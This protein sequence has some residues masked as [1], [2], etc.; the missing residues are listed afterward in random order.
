M[1]RLPVDQVRCIHLEGSGCY[2]HNGAD[3][4]GADAALLAIALP[5]RP[6][7]VQWMREE[8]HAWEPYGAAMVSSARARLDAQGNVTEWQYEVW[9]NSHNERPGPAGNLAPAWHVQKPFAKPAPKPAPQ[10]AGGGDRN[11]IP[12][13]KFGNIRVL[14]HFIPEMPLR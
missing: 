7:R 2:G 5:G 12:L 11:A 4:A 13:Y 14:H 10:P 8:E 1:L 9:S 3:D 6:V